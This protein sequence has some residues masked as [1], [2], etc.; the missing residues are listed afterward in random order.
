[1]ERWGEVLALS[2][3]N[4]PHVVAQLEKESIQS[5]AEWAQWKRANAAFIAKHHG[6]TVV[7]MIDNLLHPHFTPPAVAQRQPPAATTRPPPLTVSERDYEA[8]QGQWREGER[9]LF[10][11]AGI[12]PFH[13]DAA[14]G[15]VTV[16]L[17]LEYRAREGTRWHLFGGM[18]DPGE[19]PA[20]TA[21]REFWEETGEL[22]SLSGLESMMK[23]ATCMWFR[24]GK[25]CLYLLPVQ[26]QME[27]DFLKLPHKYKKRLHSFHRKH[28]MEASHLEWLPSSILDRGTTT[29]SKH[30]TSEMLEKLKRSGVFQALRRGMEERPAENLL[31]QDAIDLLQLKGLR[32]EHTFWLSALEEATVPSTAEE[33]TAQGL[34]I[35]FPDNRVW[36]SVL[37]SLQK[38]PAQVDAIMAEHTE[39]DARIATME[40]EL[41]SLKA[42][43]AQQQA[44]RSQVRRIKQSSALLLRTARSLDQAE[45][46]LSS[47]AVQ[48]LLE[49]ANVPLRAPGGQKKLSVAT[50]QIIL[51]AGGL[52]VPT[53]KKLAEADDTFSLAG[54]HDDLSLTERCDVRYLRTMVKHQSVPFIHPFFER[55]ESHAALGELKSQ[56][57]TV[58]A[59]CA[60]ATPSS[61]VDLLS[62]LHPPLTK[63]NWQR[64]GL[65]GPRMLMMTPLD[66]KQLFN[67]S[68]EDAKMYWQAI[69]VLRNKHTEVLS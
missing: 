13:R 7:H 50:R 3:E 5:P 58:C 18:R 51:Q 48:Q 66:L 15:S 59:V 61:L 4:F 27:S 32:A 1:M 38:L 57:H 60:C 17:P 16:L 12:L 67:L 53:A 52:S 24:G 41:T 9:K 8:V 20:E 65:N 19:S 22:L 35:G 11:S 64:A 68:P 34:P 23:A 63:L 49:Y 46:H 6:E 37:Q 42:K 40:A 36:H 31:S 45:E 39:L 28:T 54:S 62:D 33:W 14:T 30:S 2:R 56:H 26:G 29:T 47:G 69:Q 43:K 55:Y 44:V 25:Y 21:T 10:K